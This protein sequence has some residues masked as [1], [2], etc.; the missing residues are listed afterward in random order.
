M[1]HLIK[2]CFLF[3]VFLS[4]FGASLFGE[5]LRLYSS[6]K[7]EALR[8]ISSDSSL[9][10]NFS[11]DIRDDKDVVLAAVKEDGL[12]IEYASAT[13][14]SQGWYEYTDLYE[15]YEIDSII[16]IINRNLSGEKS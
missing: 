15:L 13:G 10:Q 1:K 9:F 11:D 7:D 14:S 2:H 3:L 5:P 12:N 6:D 4:L 16:F 8:I